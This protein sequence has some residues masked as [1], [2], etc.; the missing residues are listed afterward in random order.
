MPSAWVARR[1]VKDGVRYRVMFRTGGRES[2]PRYAGVFRTMRE[3]KMRRDWVAGE[4]ASLRVPDLSLLG[5]PVTAPRLAAVAE[6]WRASR[7]DV[8]EN[9]RVLRRRSRRRSGRS[10]FRSSDRR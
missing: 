7:V 8:T 10:L 9:T 1:P 4:L 3:A 6:S 5:E 2:A